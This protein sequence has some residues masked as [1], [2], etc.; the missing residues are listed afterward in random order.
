[1]IHSQEDCMGF[2]QQPAAV[3]AAIGEPAAC[4]DRKD[5]ELLS[6]S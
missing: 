6:Y 3:R 2:Q 4:Q 1:M 5:E